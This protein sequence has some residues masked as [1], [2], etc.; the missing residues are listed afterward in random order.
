M[1]LFFIKCSQ[2]YQNVTDEKK[3]TW[4]CKEPA[5]SLDYDIHCLV[6]KKPGSYPRDDF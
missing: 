6:L 5:I 1:L 2:N 4:F 3:S